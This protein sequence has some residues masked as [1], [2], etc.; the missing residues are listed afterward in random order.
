MRL[1]LHPDSVCEAVTAIEARATRPGPGL[2]ELR[3]VVAGDLDGLVIPPPAA[4]LRMDGLWRTTCLEAFVRTPGGEGYCE[5]NLSPSAAWAAYLFDGYRQGM[6]P[7]SGIEA[8]EIDVHRAG[9]RL[10]LVAR[11]DLARCGLL[12]SAGPWVIG[13]CAVIQEA[14]GRVSY[15]ALAH[16]PGRPD[17]HHP[18][19]F[20]LELPASG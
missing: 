3:Y 19:C 12:N 8:P 15:W 13:L 10:D 2:L 16:P 1:T 11:V 6:R 18:D 14:S 7:A 4:P 17:F 20:A 5:L 9:D